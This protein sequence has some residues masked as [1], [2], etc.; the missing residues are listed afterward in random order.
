MFILCQDN[1]DPLW[2]IYVA[3]FKKRIVCV[4]DKLDQKTPVILMFYLLSKIVQ[5]SIARSTIRKLIQKASYLSQCLVDDFFTRHE[6]Y[7]KRFYK[8]YARESTTSPRRIQLIPV[9]NT[10]FPA[11]V[12]ESEYDSSCGL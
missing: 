6:F 1:L 8:I 2:G 9:P 7:T 4:L 12:R 5:T 3:Y 11:F 10:C